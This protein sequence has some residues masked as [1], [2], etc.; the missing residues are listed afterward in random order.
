MTSPGLQA[1]HLAVIV[2]DD[3]PNS[4]AIAEHYRK[5]RD[6]PARNMV[7]VRIPGKPRKLTAE[8]FARLKEEIDSK[9][10][11]DIDAVLMVWTAPYA[12]ECNAITAAYTLGFDPQQCLKPCG[13]GRPSAYFNSAASSPRADS[14][15]LAMLMPTES[16]ADAK[17]L[18][19][20]GVASGFRA[21]P[22][23][24]YYLVTSDKARS[25]RVPFFPRSGVIPAKK[26]TI[27]T[28]Q[29]DVLEGAKDI[30]IYQTGQASVSKL[31]T[32]QFVPGALADHLTSW[33]GDLLGDSQMSSLRWLEAG[34]TATYGTVSEPCNHWQKFPN[35]TVLLRHY[36]NGSTA[37]EAYWKS[38]AW[39]AQGLILGEPLA[40]PYHRH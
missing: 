8:Q 30:L 18:I 31:D 25:S 26:L 22:A 11:A 28:L 9:L 15:R 23:T 3:E 4:V 6:I 27:K 16:V 33:G 5:A 37:I 12:V 2:N 10:P 17:A 35:P 24:A 38:V 19:E 7:H 29:Q 34:A 13:P 1:A 36:L 40:A 20:R 39:P 21:A 14:L 32:L